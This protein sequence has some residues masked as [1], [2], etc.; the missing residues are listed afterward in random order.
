MSER[1]AAGRANQECPKRDC[2]PIED[3]RKIPI[4]LIF[5]ALLVATVAMYG[6]AG[7]V[8]PDRATAAAFKKLDAAA[9]LAGVVTAVTTVNA[10]A[11]HATVAPLTLNG[12]FKLDLPKDGVPTGDMVLRT[13]A[14]GAADILLDAR[15]MGGQYF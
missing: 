3:M 14:G 1:P 8:P 9:H 13:A 11:E 6:L 7:P 4:A 15:T 10:T 2:P 12:A 5:A